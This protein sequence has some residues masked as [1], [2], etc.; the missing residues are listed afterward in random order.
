MA[1]IQIYCP[2]CNHHMSHKAR[3]KRVGRYGSI[4]KCPKCDHEFAVSMIWGIQ[5]TK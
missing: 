3:L 4:Y 2:R 5:K 1:W